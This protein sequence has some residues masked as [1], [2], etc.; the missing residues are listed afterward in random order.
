MFPTGTAC[1][2]LEVRV[3]ISPNII[4]FIGR[5]MPQPHNDKRTLTIAYTVHQRQKQISYV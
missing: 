2:S 5:R 3:D 1:R 4:V